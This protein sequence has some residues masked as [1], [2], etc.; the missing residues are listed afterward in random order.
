MSR[1]SRILVLA[2]VLGTPATALATGFGGGDAPSR[3]PVPARV[4]QATV[5]DV[6]GATVK[7]DRVTFDG[8]V[9]VYGKLGE[10]H[11]AVPFE[12]ITE[13]RVEPASDEGHRIVFAKLTDGTSVRITVERDLPCYGQT[14]FGN[15]RIDVEKISKV[16]FHHPG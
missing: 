11:A 10:G 8:E 4:F 12:K 5:D 1:T 16:T 13:L 6:A 2:A 14:S 9:F 3:I 15:Y 7:V